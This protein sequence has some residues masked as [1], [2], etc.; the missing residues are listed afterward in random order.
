MIYQFNFIKDRN[1]RYSCQLWALESKW[2]CV[3]RFNRVFDHL[4]FEKRLELETESVKFAHMPLVRHCLSRMDE[5]RR[6][7]MLQQ[8]PYQVLRIYL[9]WPCQALFTDAAAIVKDSLPNRSF[10]KLIHTVICQK[11]LPGWRDCDYV[12][13]LRRFWREGAEHCK[14]YVKGDGI[15]E[16]LTVILEGKGFRTHLRS[17]VPRRYLTHAGTLTENTRRC[18]NLTMLNDN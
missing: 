9:F 7:Q 4:P 15:F 1:L 6:L 2:T 13:L 16:I 18:I 5:Q 11:I 17:G 10:L 3:T 14:E 8:Y 12:D